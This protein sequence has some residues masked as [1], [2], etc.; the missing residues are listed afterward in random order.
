MFPRALLSC[1]VDIP[2]SLTEITVVVLAVLSVLTIEFHFAFS[3]VNPPVFS[4]ITCDSLH[5]LLLTHLFS[6]EVQRH[7]RAYCAC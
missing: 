3:L 2:C 4:G 6:R 5:F 7:V 1:L